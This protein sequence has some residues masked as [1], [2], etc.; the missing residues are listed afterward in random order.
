MSRSHFE[1]DAEKDEANQEKHH[2]SFAVAQQALSLA[3]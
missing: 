1:W 3:A 2:V